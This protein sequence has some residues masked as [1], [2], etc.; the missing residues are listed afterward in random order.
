MTLKNIMMQWHQSTHTLV[1]GEND[2]Q[3]L[4]ITM[5]QKEICYV[6]YHFPQ[7]PLYL[8]QA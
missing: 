8:P 7:I 6:G 4:Q 1:Y 2:S 3:V 5:E